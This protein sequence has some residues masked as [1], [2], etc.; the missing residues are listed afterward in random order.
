MNSCVTGFGFCIVSG[1]CSGCGFAFCC[2]D[3]ITD[4]CWVLFVVSLVI[5]VFGRLVFRI[6]FDVIVQCLYSLVCLGCFSVLC[7]WLGL[8]VPGFYCCD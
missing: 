1:F 8:V 4:L 2:F 7:F 3:L 5:W 6:D